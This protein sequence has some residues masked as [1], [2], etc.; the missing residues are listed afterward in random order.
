MGDTKPP[1][2]HNWTADSRDRVAYVDLLNSEHV[3]VKAL[4][5]TMG[6]TLAI[7]HWRC[8]I[9]AAGVE[10]MLGRDK[11][12]NLQLWLMDFGECR[13]FTSAPRDIMTQLVDAVVHN[14]PYWPKYTKLYGLRDIW[15]TFRTTYLQISGY[16]LRG[17]SDGS[18]LRSLP[19]LFIDELE[20]LRGPSELM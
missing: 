7:F 5:S 13:A 2:T 9:D 10:F 16:I 11:R 14:E 20:R 15:A 12:G 1:L 4:S 17:L 6:A 3:N 19:L 18:C 8:G